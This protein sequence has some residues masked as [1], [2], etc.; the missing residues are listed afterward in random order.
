MESIARHKLCCV[1]DQH[2]SSIAQEG[3]ESLGPR[4]NSSS[5]PM[6]VGEAADEAAQDHQSLLVASVLLCLTAM[7]SVWFDG[8]FC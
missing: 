3:K 1:R 8:C 5:G 2:S 6:N 4:L 7:F